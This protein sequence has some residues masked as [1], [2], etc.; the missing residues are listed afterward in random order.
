MSGD[1]N[2]SWGY[3]VSGLLGHKVVFRVN[4]EPQMTSVTFDSK[5]WRSYLFVCL[6]FE[7]KLRLLFLRVAP[8]FNLFLIH[9]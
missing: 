5:K 1:L 3:E 9:F 4:G 7:H 8:F 6:N 2:A